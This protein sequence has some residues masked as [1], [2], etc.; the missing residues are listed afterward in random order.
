[1][2]Y[3][4]TVRMRRATEQSPPISLTTDKEAD[5]HLKPIKSGEDNTS[6]ELATEDNGAKVTGDLDVTGDI[7]GLEIGK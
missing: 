1:M 5:K 3:S 2:A 4:K 7:N 6:L